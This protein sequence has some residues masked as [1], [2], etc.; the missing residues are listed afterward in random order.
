MPIEKGVGR[1]LAG[2]CIKAKGVGVGGRDT[3]FGVLGALE[4]SGVPLGP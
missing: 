1:W 2:P 4:G 3:G